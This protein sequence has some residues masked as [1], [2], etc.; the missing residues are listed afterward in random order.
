MG[1]P[2]TVIHGLAGFEHHLELEPVAQTVDLVEVD[3]GLTHEV[4][5][6]SFTDGPDL[7]E[8]AFSAATKASGSVVGALKKSD[9]AGP[10]E[11]SRR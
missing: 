3:P 5:G 9:W 6:A 11:S 10:S 8:A 4:E 7:T 2:C 1:D